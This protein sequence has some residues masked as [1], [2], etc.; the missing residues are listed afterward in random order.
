MEEEKLLMAHKATRPPPIAESSE[1]TC[2]NT[3]THIQGGFRVLNLS[4]KMRS[5]AQDVKDLLQILTPV[6]RVCLPK[7]LLGHR[8]QGGGG[9][10][11]GCCQFWEKK[12]FLAP[13]RKEEKN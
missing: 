5:T 13:Q 10:E 6:A 8:N 9:R 3:H 4:E 11:G 7:L 1:Q 12:S 2:I